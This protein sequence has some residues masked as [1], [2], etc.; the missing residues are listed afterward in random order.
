MCLYN[1]IK[2]WFTQDKEDYIYIDDKYYIGYANGS[3]KRRK[4]KVN[5]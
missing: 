2:A 5:F 4:K 3:G 1:L